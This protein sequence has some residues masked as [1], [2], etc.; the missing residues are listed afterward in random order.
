MDLEGQGR[1]RKM[2]GPSLFTQTMTR[3]ICHQERDRL[4][5]DLDNEGRPCCR[6]CMRGT[7]FSAPRVNSILL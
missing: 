4:D 1:N 3:H 2:R 5:D 6:E 7:A